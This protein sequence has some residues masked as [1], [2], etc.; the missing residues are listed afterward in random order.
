MK[1]ITSLTI[2]IATLAALPFYAQAQVYTGIQDALPVQ[3][4]LDGDVKYDAWYNLSA[5]PKD[6]T[7]N[8]VNYNIA[9]LSGYPNGPFVSAPVW[10]APV[11]SQFYSA[12]G[13]DLSTTNGAGANPSNRAAF[14]KV[15]N[16][17]YSGG[18]DKFN[19]NG[20]RNETAWGP[21][22]SF[23]PY[24]AGDSLYAISFANNFNA[25]GGT[26]GVFEA[27][28]I[29]DLQNVVLQLEIG[30]ANGYD[31]YDKDVS[32]L[33]GYDGT[34]QPFGPASARQVGMLSDFSSYSPTLT[35]TFGN[36]TTTSLTADYGAL[37]DKGFNGTASMPTGPGGTY[38]DE[39]IW[40]NLYGF[41]W[42]LSAYS[43]IV[44]FN[45]TWDVVEHSQ[46]YAAQ[47][48]QGSL[49]SGEILSNYIA[50]PEPGTY[51]A[52]FGGMLCTGLL[53][54]RHRRSNNQAA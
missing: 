48:D 6:R 41:Q 2:T 3:I 30:A 10:S 1:P 51:A 9:G 47:L 52:I 19:A 39:D 36:R 31:F 46:F 50:I 33:S 32:G 24:T 17:N 13:Y 4:A 35:L 5:Q 21:L 25:F 11:Q 18:I 34:G 7:I 38:I 53:I 12:T 45:V 16:Q 8:G 28:P 40:V 20:T 43:D 27:N 42:D 23:A 14:N 44:S 22:G 15:R 54:R 26:L 37:L 29:S 49:F